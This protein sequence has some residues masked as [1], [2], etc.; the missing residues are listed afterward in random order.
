MATAPTMIFWPASSERLA[1]ADPTRPSHGVA[2][3]LQRFGYRVIPVTPTAEAVLAKLG[4]ADSRV[5][6]WR[7]RMLENQGALVTSDAG[8]AL[9]LETE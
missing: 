3:S 4:L 8:R 6:D 1:T 5:A 9:A 2:R 7:R